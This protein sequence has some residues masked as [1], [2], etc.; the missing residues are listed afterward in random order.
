MQQALTVFQEIDERMERGYG[1]QHLALIANARGEYDRAKL[2]LDEDLQT[3]QEFN[4]VNGMADLLQLLSRLAI[5][6]G[7]YDQAEAYIRRGLAICKEAGRLEARGLL[8]QLGS[9]RR[10]QGNYKEAEHLCGES[11]ELAAA[12][13]HQ[14]DLAE[15]LSNLGRLACDQGEYGR[16][17]KY[18][19][20]SLA[21]WQQVNNEIEIAAV[22][23]HL[24]HV[25]A[26]LDV[27]REQEARQ[28][29][30]Q[31]LQL[32]T[33]QRLAPLVLDVFIGMAELLVREGDLQVAVELLT[34]A[35]G[36]S[37]GTHET[38]EKADRRLA[39]LADRLPADA[40]AAASA[41]SQTLDWHSTTDRLIRELSSGVLPPSMR[42]NH[43]AS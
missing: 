21:I 8:G 29:F 7:Q 26:A 23:C 9:V 13:H 38:K 27:T 35:E 14:P 25:L 18:L 2:L 24:G 30:A 15:S 19:L 20:E 42:M 39:A 17:E 34:L 12:A 5:A 4:D 37:A 16:A 32:A 36:H 11:F 3:R 1:V 31:A 22:R 41:Q 6:Q 28:Y 33:R 43:E 40:V 10:L